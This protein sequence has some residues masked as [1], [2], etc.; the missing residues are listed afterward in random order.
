MVKR[1]SRSTYHHGDLKS[2]VLLAAEKI[3]ERDGLQAVTLREVARTVGV[4]H[5]APKNHFGDLTGLLT[6]LAA[7]GYTKFAAALAEAVNSTSGNAG[8]R[9]RAMG[10]AYVVFARAHPKLFLLMFH[11]ERL[12][13]KRPS[14]LAAIDES[15]QSLRTAVISM[16]EDRPMKPLQVAAKATASWAFVH[17]LAMLLLDGRLKNTMASLPG[18][19]VEIFLEAVLDAASAGD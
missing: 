13:M 3:L 9:L 12:D 14:L 15:R 8:D 18:V 4:S 1:V 2:A 7:G 6:E 5:T 17:G 19:D 16:A 11:S 10:S